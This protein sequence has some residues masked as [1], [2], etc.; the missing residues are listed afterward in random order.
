MVNFITSATDTVDGSV[1]VSC[2]PPSGSQFPFGSTAVQCSATDAHGNT[3]TGMFFVKVQD[4]TPPVI[5]KIEASPSSIWPPNHKF[6]SVKL[7]VTA[8][9]LP[10]STPVSTIISVSS[11][12]PDNGPGDGNTTGDW[13]IS[14]PLTVDLRAERAGNSDRIY[15]ITVDCVDASGNHSQGT[16]KVTVGQ[17]RGRVAG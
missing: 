17:T 15:T 16:V 1:P 8:T 5:K 10:D 12:Q 13:H 4:T 6:V 14:G 3:A 11:N 2:T 9:D 7:T